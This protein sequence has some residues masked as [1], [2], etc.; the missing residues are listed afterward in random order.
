M[1]VIGIDP[2]SVICGYG[3]IDMVG[4]SF[5]LVELGVIKAKLLSDEFNGRLQILNSALCKVIERTKP[6][7]SAFET[8]FYAKNVQSLVKLSHARAATIISAKQ[9]ELEVFEY[10]PNEVKKSVTGKGKAN[11][12]QVQYMVKK[13]LG[14]KENPEFYDSTDALAIALCHCMKQ[15]NKSRKT[16][17]NWEQFVKENPGRVV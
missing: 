8:I 17:H 3:V 9:N 4:N 5:E 13:I 10:S 12:E 2:G 11:K 14:I 1:R 16:A 15:G 7:V 6:D